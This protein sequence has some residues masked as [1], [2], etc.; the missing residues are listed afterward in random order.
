VS[1]RDRGFEDFYRAGP[2]TFSSPT[3]RPPPK[4]SFRHGSQSFERGKGI[5]REK[6]QPFFGTVIAKPTNDFW[7]ERNLGENECIEFKRCPKTTGAI[8]LMQVKNIKKLTNQE[9]PLI[10]RVFQG[11]SHFFGID[12]IKNLTSGRPR[13]AK[14]AGRPGTSAAIRRE[15][16]NA[17]GYYRNRRDLLKD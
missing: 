13:I 17:Y 6:D 14:R 15:T 2:D 8:F 9:S 10:L 3:T 11:H 16:K 7:G 5:L 4:G 12:P 1:T